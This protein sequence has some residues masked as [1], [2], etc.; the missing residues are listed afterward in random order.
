[1]AIAD[2]AAASTIP[3]ALYPELNVRVGPGAAAQLV[4][5]VEADLVLNA[6]VGFAGLESTLAALESGRGLALANKESLVCAGSLV[7]G[8]ARRQG[9]EILPVDSEHSALYQLV[10]AAE[11]GGGRIR[12]HHRFGRTVPRLGRFGA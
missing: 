10:G 5:E 2:E 9:V 1:M 8:L 4:R 6:I 12:G 7:T 11:R 3:R